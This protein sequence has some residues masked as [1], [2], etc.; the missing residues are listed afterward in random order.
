MAT[1]A[2]QRQSN[3]GMNGARD[4]AS[5]AGTFFPFLSFLLF[6]ALLKIFLQLD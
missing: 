4:V 3:A 5:Q 2:H 1:D 6:F